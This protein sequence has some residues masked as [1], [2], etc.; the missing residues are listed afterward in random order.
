MST[1]KKLTHEIR[2]RLANKA[3]CKQIEKDHAALDRAFKAARKGAKT[4]AA[5]DELEDAG[6]LRTALFSAGKR[7]ACKTMQSK[8]HDGK[9]RQPK[10]GDGGGHV[11]SQRAKI[12]PLDGLAGMSPAASLRRAANAAAHV[13]TATAPSCRSYRVAN[14][15][16]R[17]ATRMAKRAGMKAASAGLQQAA[18]DA[19]MLRDA[20]KQDGCKLVLKKRRARK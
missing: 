18:K 3:T 2:E 15:A 7:H 6:K 1:L 14:S 17:S 13:A 8:I 5:R 10:W 11:R 9:Y 12:S 4:A 19:K 20:A 16:L